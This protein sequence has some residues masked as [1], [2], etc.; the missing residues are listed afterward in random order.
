MAY[1]VDKVCHRSVSRMMRHAAIVA[2]KIIVKEMV[3]VDG[4]I[5]HFKKVPV[6]RMHCRD[7]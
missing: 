3:I 2:G 6:L 4:W 5:L 7:K 1:P